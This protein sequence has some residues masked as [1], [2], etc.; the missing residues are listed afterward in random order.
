MRVPPQQHILSVG[1]LLLVTIRAP[2]SLPPS[3][4]PVV[5][6]SSK[7]SCDTR[8]QLHKMLYTQ[9]ATY[10]RCHMHKSEWV[11]GLPFDSNS[12]HS[13]GHSLSR[14]HSSAFTLPLKMGVETLSR[15]ADQHLAAPK[16][17]CEVGRRRALGVK[18]A[19]VL[20]VYLKSRSLLALFSPMCFY[21]G[22]FFPPSIVLCLFVFVFV[23]SMFRL[24]RAA[25]LM[26]SRLY[27]SLSCP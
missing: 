27:M 23:F 6:S 9:E 17:L 22:V 16:A 1:F 14:D 26:F 7:T 2:S 3:I 11:D 15:Y 21:V 19:A 24:F 18:L 5:P 10:A 8:C 20:L 13:C 25:F 4:L 12:Q